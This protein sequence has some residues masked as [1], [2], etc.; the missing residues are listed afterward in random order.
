MEKEIILL[1]KIMN[2]KNKYEFRDKKFYWL[3]P[4]TNENIG[5]YYNRLDFENKN[6]LTVTSSGDHILNAILL[7]ANEINAFDI[8]PLAKYYVA[9]KIAAL[10]SLNLDQFISFLY[11][12]NIFKQE[13]SY[14]NY[15]IYL[16]RIREYLDTKSKIFCDYMF[17]NY[18]TKEIYKSK[19]FSKN[20]LN[21]RGLIEAN[22]YLNEENFKKLKKIIENVVINYFDSD[23]KN[24]PELKRKFDII[25]LSNIPSFLDNDISK[26]KELR[27]LIDKLK[28]DDSQVILNY[29][30][31]NIIN[32]V[33]NGIL[34][35]NFKEIDRIFSEYEYYS[36]ES[37]D[38]L[39]YNKLK[40]GFYYNYDKVLMTK[41]YK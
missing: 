2:K 4:F 30:Y 18:T 38:N 22:P 6:V 7:G 23:L 17:E 34:V 12:K 26:L 33:S 35:Y 11:N 13:E 16:Y 37:A 39:S 3:Y 14:L 15:K 9:L 25:I 10:K 20:F 1:K 41:K 31:N 28:K 36:F 27:E 5:G 29:Y 24:I 21:I 40:R 19:L 8:N 32:S